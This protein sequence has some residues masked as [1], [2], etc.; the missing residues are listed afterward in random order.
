MAEF[1]KMEL[2]EL[3]MPEMLEEQGIGEGRRR[4][5]ETF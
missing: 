2:P 3:E 1:E 5:G 4:G